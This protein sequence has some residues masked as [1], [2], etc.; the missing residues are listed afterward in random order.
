[1]KLQNTP[2]QIKAIAEAL[3]AM[4]VS[5]FT[6]KSC[7]A[8]YNAQQN[9]SGR[10]HYVEDD[11]LRWHHSRVNSAGHRADGLLFCIT[12]SVA[13]DMHN[14]S[15][16]TRCVVFDVF[17]TTVYHPDLE[18]T[19][20]TSA[21]AQKA[22][23]ATEFDLVAHYAEAIKSKLY[24]VRQEVTALESAADALQ[25]IENESMATL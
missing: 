15:R 24:W 18:N 4:R 11:T 14:R 20:K 23:A 8:K 2:E 10:T 7:D 16:G 13:L 19:F 9:L 12:E 22:C 6:N 1:M 3:K 21:Q 25:D 17:G 5:L